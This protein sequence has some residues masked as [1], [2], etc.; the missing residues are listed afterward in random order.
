MSASELLI[1]V[2][3]VYVAPHMN[4]V[5]SSALGILFSLMGVYLSLKGV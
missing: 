5:F 2:G 3:A 4:G 1:V